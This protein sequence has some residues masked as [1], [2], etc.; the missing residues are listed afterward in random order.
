[1]IEV[2]INDKAQQVAKGVSIEQLVSQFAGAGP[3]AVAL[4]GEF[5]GKENYDKTAVSDKDKIDIL[6]P[7]QGG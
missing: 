6:S 3:F 4:N 1:M 5:V 7:I 2:F